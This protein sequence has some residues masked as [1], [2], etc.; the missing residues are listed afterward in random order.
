MELKIQFKH[1]N[2]GKLSLNK[3][4]YQEIKKQ[5]PVSVKL[6]DYGDKAGES[7]FGIN[8]DMDID[9]KLKILRKE[10]SCLFR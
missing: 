3:D 1:Q 2:F 10:K 5:K 6:V 9:E 8:Q 7:V 4:K